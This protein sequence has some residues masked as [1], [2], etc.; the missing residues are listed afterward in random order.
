MAR[1][2]CVC[3]LL[4]LILTIDVGWKSG[5]PGEAGVKET[6]LDGLK[7]TN[8]SAEPGSFLEKVT[9]PFFLLNFQTILTPHFELWSLSGPLGARS[10]ARLKL[11][12]QSWRQVSPPQGSPRGLQAA[13]ATKNF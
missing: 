13:T 10:V 3:K 7:K 9:R 2:C 1:N 6:V 5:G 12:G 4:K 11:L 8:S